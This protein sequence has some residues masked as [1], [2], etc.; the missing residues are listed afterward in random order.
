M[1]QE[2]RNPRLQ[3][4]DFPGREGTP[5]AGTGNTGPAGPFFQ[6]ASLKAPSGKDLKIRDTIEIRGIALRR[7]LEGTFFGRY[8]ARRERPSM[9]NR[10][11]HQR[12]L[13]QFTIFRFGVTV[14]SCCS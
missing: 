9:E 3:V 7:H 10:P 13:Q 1:N 4:Y 8:P 12:Q 5:D 6:P 2:S 14:T 11:S